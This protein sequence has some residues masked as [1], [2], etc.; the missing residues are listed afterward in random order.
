MMRKRKST[1]CWS[2][3]F[4]IMSVKDHWRQRHWHRYWN[5][6]AVSAS[7]TFITRALEAGKHVFSANKDLL[8]FMSELLEIAKNTKWLLIMKLPWL[9]GSQSFELW[10]TLWPQTR[11]PRF[12]V[13]INGTLTFHDDPNGRKKA[14]L[15]RVF[16]EAQHPSYAE[17][18]SNHRRI[19]AATRWWS[20]AQFALNEY[21][22]DQK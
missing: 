10:W 19:D 11:W 15:M 21:P 3:R 4:V 9:V 5:W 22:G 8:M 16:S 13:W 7:W 18:W 6:W 17:K 20:W 14:G 1:S 12:L 2:T